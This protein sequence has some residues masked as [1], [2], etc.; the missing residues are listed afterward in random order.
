M[1]EIEINEETFPA[2]DFIVDQ[3]K[4]IIKVNNEKLIEY[5]KHKNET[6]ISLIDY[7]K[8]KEQCNNCRTPAF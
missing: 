3:E 2:T 5:I 4:E 6:M 7:N 1:K 8:Q